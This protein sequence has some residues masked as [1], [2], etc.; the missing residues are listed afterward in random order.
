MHHLDGQS[1]RPEPHTSWKALRAQCLH[2]ALADLFIERG[3]ES[4]LLEQ[5]SKGC[6]FLLGLGLEH[7]EQTL[8]EG[9]KAK[10]AAPQL[11]LSSLGEEGFSQ[12]KAKLSTRQRQPSEQ[13]STA[14]RADITKRRAEPVDSSGSS[15]GIGTSALHHLLL[16]DVGQIARQP[17]S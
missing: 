12:G 8:P 10:L 7:P 16:R 4:E 6:S 5:R 17:G 9:G 1:P 2:F 3:L 13:N 15:G 14:L 11:L